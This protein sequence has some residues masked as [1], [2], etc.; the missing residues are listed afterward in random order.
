MGQLSSSLEGRKREDP[1]NEVSLLFSSS[2]I[3]Q[4]SRRIL[5]YF[6]GKLSFKSCVS[7]KFKKISF[8]KARGVVQIKC[9][10]CLLNS[11]SFH[12]T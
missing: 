1:R 9:S 6:Y 3:M 7:Q 11:V 5:N 8:L 10:F 12:L 4:C 2:V